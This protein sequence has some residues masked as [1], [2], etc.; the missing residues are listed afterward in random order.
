MQRLVI[1]SDAGLQIELI[2]RQHD[3]RKV[4]RTREITLP[5]DLADR[6]RKAIAKA[7][8]DDA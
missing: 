4:R 5:D 6:L 3:D 8:R 2:T 1:E 7:L